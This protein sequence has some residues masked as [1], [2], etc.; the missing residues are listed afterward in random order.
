[1]WSRAL[2]DIERIGEI[3]HDCLQRHGGPYLFGRQRCMADAMYAPVC[4]R[5]QTYHVAVDDT[6]TA[7]CRT[8]MA[9]PEMQEWVAAARAEPDDV[10]ELDMDF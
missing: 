1:V 8:I 9:M 5:F 7:Y 3:W 6:A 2:A 4:T 10:D